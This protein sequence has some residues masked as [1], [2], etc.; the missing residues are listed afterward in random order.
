MEQQNLYTIEGKSLLSVIRN[1]W[2]HILVVTFLGFVAAVIFSSPSF[3]PPI[4]KSRAIIYPSNIFPYATENATEQMI[5]IMES[6]DIRDRAIADFDL[7][8]HYG[9]D[10]KGKFPKT[11]LYGIYGES[12]N[13][14]KTQYESAEITVFDKDPVTASTLCDSLISYLNQKIISMHR[15]KYEEVVK[16]QRDR[17]ET[18]RHHMDSMENALRV[19]RV[20]YGILEFE[21]QVEPFAEVYYQALSAGRAGNGHSRLDKI[22]RNFAEK[23]GEYV[24]LKEHLWRVRGYFNEV[25]EEYDQADMDFKKHLTFVNVVT[26]PEPAERKTYPLRMLIVLGVTASTFFFTFLLA[27]VYERFRKT[28]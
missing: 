23:G 21:E 5:Q 4:F 11:E 13:V 14:S 6:E 16:I 2:K 17:L 28:S 15:S 25:K 10:P 7:V 1:W 12:V 8:K 22:E 9:V 3:M 20:D 18:V 27:L 19:L 26:P 24:A